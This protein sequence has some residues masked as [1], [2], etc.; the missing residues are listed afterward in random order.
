M[1]F[2]SNAKLNGIVKELKIK[3]E[4]ECLFHVSLSGLFFSSTKTMAFFHGMLNVLVPALSLAILLLILPPFLLFKI[5]RFIV[6]SISREDVAGKVV[7]ITGASS[8]IG[9]VRSCMF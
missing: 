7:L 6:R 9:E 2:T 3:T 8:G 1:L 4:F 5:L